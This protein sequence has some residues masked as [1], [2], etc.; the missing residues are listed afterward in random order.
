MTKD[1][2][3]QKGAPTAH[4]I[5]H[6]IVGLLKYV[7]GNQCLGS[8]GINTIQKNKKYKLFCSRKSLV[9]EKKSNTRQ[10]GDSAYI[11]GKADTFI[12]YFVKLKRH[13]EYLSF[14][15]FVLSSLNE[16]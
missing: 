16:N 10:N 8:C 5:R 6:V 14:S 1:I 15:T 7:T 3:N 4:T 11:F 12:I 2:K 13:D 9:Q